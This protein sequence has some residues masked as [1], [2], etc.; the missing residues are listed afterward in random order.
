MNEIRYPYAYIVEDIVQSVSLFCE[1][2]TNKHPFYNSLVPIREYDESLLC[3]R[4]I[5]LDSDGY[6]LFEA[7]P[8]PDEQT[9]TVTE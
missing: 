5:G 9:K 7:V 8:E 4:Y 2:A 3:Q 1:R 6:G